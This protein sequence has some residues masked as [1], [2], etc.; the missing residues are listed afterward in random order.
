[1]ATLLELLTRIKNEA[2]VK[3]SDDLDDWIK[4]IINERIRDNTNGIVRY[5][6]VVKDVAL[7]I[8]SDKQSQY[9]LPV[10]FVKPVHVEFSPYNST[11]MDHWYPIHPANEY[12]QPVTEGLPR[13]YELAGNSLYIRPYSLIRA[14]EHRLRM[15]YR[16]RPT[17]LTLDADVLEVPELED[18]IVQEA[19]A[20]VARYHKA[21]EGELYL[22]DGNRSNSTTL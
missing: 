3:S 21:P 14:G 7:T 19:V 22:R 18:V 6:M 1:M 9:T 5:Q 2:R 15:T 16:K 10:G 17:T 20:R 8:A 12:R 4:S 11:D 13:I